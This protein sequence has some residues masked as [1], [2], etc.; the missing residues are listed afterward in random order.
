MAVQYGWVGDGFGQKGAGRQMEPAQYT[1]HLRAARLDA[2]VWY[3]PS[4]QRKKNGEIIKQKKTGEGLRDCYFALPPWVS[5]HLADMAEAGR[6]AEA[7]KIV[8]HALKTAMQT[9]RERTKYKLVGCAVHPDSRGVLGYH[10]QYQSASQGQLLGR[11]ADGRRGRKGLRLA[12]D[13][14]SSVARLSEY[15]T[16][17]DWH[18]VLKQDCDDIA[19]NK[20]VDAKLREVLGPDW[21]KVEAAARQYAE[22]WKKRRDEALAPAP[23]DPKI[24]ELKAEVADLKKDVQIWKGHAQSLGQYHQEAK[25]Q[26]DMLREACK[27]VLAPVAYAEVDKQYGSM[28]YAAALAK[29]PR[30]APT[31]APSPPQGDE[32]T[33]QVRSDLLAGL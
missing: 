6:V 9:L 27:T 15:V 11:S 18:G 13:A 5:H 1:E 4:K 31:L 23:P 17:E 8:G 25:A 33:Q 22:D 30:V 32:R 24:A 3:I 7:F 19:V 12:G 26:H 29:R 16:V 10:I 21:P 14:M 2:S 20:A 28:V